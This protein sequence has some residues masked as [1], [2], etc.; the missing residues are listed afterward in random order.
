MENE[1]K[2][3]EIER[4]FIMVQAEDGSQIKCEV[5]STFEAEETGKTY[6]VYTPEEN[7]GENATLYGVELVVTEAGPTFIG[8]TDPKD[9]EIVKDF[10]NK[11]LED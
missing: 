1:K 3:E 7:D 6:V 11:M 4:E 9:E 10:I 2:V 5:L 8:L